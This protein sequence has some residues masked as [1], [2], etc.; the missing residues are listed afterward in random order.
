MI[1]YRTLKSF[2]FL[3]VAIHLAQ[4]LVVLEKHG[5][6]KGTGIWKIPT[7]MVEEVCVLNE[8]SL[9]KSKGFNKYIIAFTCP[10]RGYLCRSNKRSKRGNRSKQLL[11]DEYMN[12]YVVC[13]LSATLFDDK[14]CYIA[15]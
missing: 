8:V 6:F 5:R 7:G 14:I 15:G 13:L 12:T 1:L 10:G 11:T 3:P 9:E 2:S 4:L